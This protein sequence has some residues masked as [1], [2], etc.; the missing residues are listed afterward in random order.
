MRIQAPLSGLDPAILQ[1]TGLDLH[2]GTE[3]RHA[4]AGK[5]NAHADGAC[6]LER[7]MVDGII[8]ANLFVENFADFRFSLRSAAGNL[9]I[10]S[11]TS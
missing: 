10:L 6:I 8:P 1:R 5:G 7:R 11:A 4:C 2:V 9:A 3:Y